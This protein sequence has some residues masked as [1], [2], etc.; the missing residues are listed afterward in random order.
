MTHIVK[1]EAV[2]KVYSAG[3]AVLD[4]LNLALPAGEFVYVIGGSGAGKTSLLK[5]LATEELAT[6]GKVELFG[7]DLARA[8]ASQLQAIRRVIGYVPQDLKLIEDLTLQENL[9]IAVK[10]GG[11]RAQDSQIRS[12][13]DEL[14]QI[15]ALASKRDQPVSRLSGGEKQRVAVA[16][17]L[18]RSP[19]LLILDEPT[20]AQ[21]RDQTWN[22]M[23][24]V[25]NVNAAGTTVILATHDREIV[26]RVRKRSVI[27]S[28]GTLA[29]EES[30]CLV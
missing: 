12:R 29:Q 22:L 2:Q 11:A 20:G 23:E 3:I 5:L 28:A 27:L 13:M 25:L 24:R 26:R 8:T 6:R 10:L 16:R 15:F 9:D 14:L 19:E 1:L 4:Q 17:A 30:G 21:D 7:Y 18:V